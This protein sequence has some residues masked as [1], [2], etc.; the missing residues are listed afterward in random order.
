MAGISD[1]LEYVEIFLLSSRQE[2]LNVLL[3]TAK[4]EPVFKLPNTAQGFIQV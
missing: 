3:A 1:D 4:I 2:K